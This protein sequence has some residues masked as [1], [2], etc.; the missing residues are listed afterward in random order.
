M[1]LG[2]SKYFQAI[3]IVAIVIIWIN[4]EFVCN[5]YEFLTCFRRS[6][7]FLCVRLFRIVFSYTIQWFVTPMGHALEDKSP[8]WSGSRLGVGSLLLARNRLP[9]VSS[10]N[11]FLVVWPE[12]LSSLQSFLRRRVY[13]N[14]TPSPDNKSA[15]VALLPRRAGVRRTVGG[16]RWVHRAPR[17]CFQQGGSGGPRSMPSGIAIG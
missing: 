8:W 17:P 5:T 12:P 10:H 13:G 9:C 15:K 1:Q 3:N 11:A 2:I 16:G 6:C 7:A 4:F 14:G